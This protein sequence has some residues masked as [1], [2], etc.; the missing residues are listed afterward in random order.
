MR[1]TGLNFLG[2]KM[3]DHDKKIIF[4]HF[5]KT[6]GSSIERH[7]G[8]SEHGETRFS[9]HDEKNKKIIVTREYHHMSVKDY[10]VMNGIDIFEEYFTFSICRNPF[11][12]FVSHFFWDVQKYHDSKRTNSTPKERRR[13]IVEECNSDFNLYLEK[14]TERAAINPRYPFKW[15]SMKEFMTGVNFVGRFENLQEDFDLICNKIGVPTAKLP[16]A[17]KSKP[18]P[19]YSEFYNKKSVNIVYDLLRDDIDHFGY[20]FERKA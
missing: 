12:W 20:S 4:F 13:F 1:W 14:A 5:V 7:F 9:L 19:H 11:D 2:G 3:T 18:R 10:V 15:P 17:K 6:G 8:G 16:H